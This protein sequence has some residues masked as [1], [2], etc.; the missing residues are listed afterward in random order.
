MYGANLDQV[1]FAHKFLMSNELEATWLGKYIH[2]NKKILE[3]YLLSYC[4]VSLYF[5][6]LSDTSTTFNDFQVSS[7]VVKNLDQ[8]FFILSF[9]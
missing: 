6:Y 9:H 8:H 7:G 1:K 5:V 3:N 2:R 4:F